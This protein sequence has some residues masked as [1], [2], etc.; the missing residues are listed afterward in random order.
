[1]NIT[2]FITGSVFTA[3]K[4]AIVVLYKTSFFWLPILLIAFSLILWIRYVRYRF[5]YKEEKVLLE[6]KIPQDIKKSPAAMEKIGRA[7]V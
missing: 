5:L 3:L 1:M 2:G 7:H 4:D 6:V